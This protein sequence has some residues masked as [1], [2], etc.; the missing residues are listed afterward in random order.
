M[1]PGVPA[2]AGQRLARHRSTKRALIPE[3]KHREQHDESPKKRRSASGRLL[4]LL[5]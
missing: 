3:R 1:S 4:A 5:P 2:W